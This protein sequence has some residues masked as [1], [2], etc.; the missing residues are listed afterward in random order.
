MSTPAQ[1][2]QEK[3]KAFQKRLLNFRRKEKLCIYQLAKMFGVSTSAMS[4]WESGAYLPDKIRHK[5]IASVLGIQ[6]EDLFSD[7]ETDLLLKNASLKEIFDELKSR[8]IILPAHNT[9]A[10]TPP[11]TRTWAKP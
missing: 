11:P 4:S 8:S 10:T 7:K 9:H 5:T 3:I 1:R 6:P 2:K